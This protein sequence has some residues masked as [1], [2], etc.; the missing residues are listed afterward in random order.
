MGRSIAGIFAVFGLLVYVY[1]PAIAQTD[2][3]KEAMHARAAVDAA[4]EDYFNPPGKYV[5][6]VYTVRNIIQGVRIWTERHT[7][8]PESQV[9]WETYFSGRIVLWDRATAFVISENANALTPKEKVFIGAL[10]LL[11]SQTNEA[12]FAL[13]RRMDELK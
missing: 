6:H 11:N 13:F 4:K 10:N 12:L 8:D 1:S 9:L 3:R 2:D 7:N 5:R